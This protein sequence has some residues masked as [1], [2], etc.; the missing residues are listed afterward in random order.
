MR[1]SGLTI[2]VACLGVSVVAAGARAQSLMQQ[3]MEFDRQFDRQL[4]QL[5]QQ[6]AQSQQQLW[7][8]YLQQNGPWLRQQYQAYLASGQM[9]VTFEQ[10]A[11]YMLMTANGTNVQGALQAQRDQFRGQQ[12]AARTRQEGYDDYRRGMQRNSEAT[13][14][15]L[16]NYSQQAIRGNA[17][18][19][20]PQTG[21]TLW[22]PYGQ[23]PG[24]VYTY[25]GNRYVQDQ[26][27]TYYQWQGNGW[28]MMQ[29]GQR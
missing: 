5:Q 28:A 16:N 15:T 4:G 17:P 27:G 25:G 22:L 23:Q 19:V 14:R 24:Q 8:S 9:P 21:G 1:V 7:Q 11:Y 3:N 18:Y 26:Q 10:F 6:N 12:D 20:D 13:D 2:I 29:P